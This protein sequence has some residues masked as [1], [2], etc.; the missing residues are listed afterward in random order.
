MDYPVLTDKP[1]EYVAQFKGTV[2]VQPKSTAVICGNLP[3]VAAEG[4]DTDKKINN[5]VLAALV[6]SPLWKQEKV[7]KEKAKAGVPGTEK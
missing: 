5:E 1:G 6:A 3:L 2:V 4:L 7:K